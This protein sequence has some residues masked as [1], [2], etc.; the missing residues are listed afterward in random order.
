MFRDENFGEASIVLD[1]RG[2]I[3]VEG[4]VD[5]RPRSPASWTGELGFGGAA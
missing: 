5:P 1:G 3:L 2:Q 4:I